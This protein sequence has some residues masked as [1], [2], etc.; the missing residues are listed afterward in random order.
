M[1]FQNSNRFRES[2]YDPSMRITDVRGRQRSLR[3]LQIISNCFSDRER[4]QFLS[5]RTPF[6]LPSYLA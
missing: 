2:I 5:S 6:A 4:N 3:F 1:V